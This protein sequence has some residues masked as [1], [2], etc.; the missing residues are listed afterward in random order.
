MPSATGGRE[1]R[2]AIFCAAAH[3][4]ATQ[5]RAR[6]LTLATWEV[7][8][9]AIEHGGGQPVIT[10]GVACDRVTALIADRGSRRDVRG[11]SGMSGMSEP[12]ARA[13][14]GRGQRIID[15]L[16]DEVRIHGD[17][18]AVYVE[19]TIRLPG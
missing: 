6:D 4:G 13:P 9:N 5:D 16:V 1:M 14:R 10:I 8:L 12:D 11:G 15:A 17:A 18:A 2:A 7:V 19:L 3:G